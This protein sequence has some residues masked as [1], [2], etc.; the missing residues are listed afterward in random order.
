[1][2]CFLK[3]NNAT[4]RVNKGVAS[5][6]K[7]SFVLTLP[8]MKHPDWRGLSGMLGQWGTSRWRRRPSRCPSTSSWTWTSSCCPRYGLSSTSSGQGFLASRWKAQCR[9]KNKSYKS[10]QTNCEFSFYEWSTSIGIKIGQLCT[11]ISCKSD[12]DDIDCNKKRFKEKF[13]Q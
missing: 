1:M 9:S 3:L 6:M 5:R 7:R 10:L 8:E 2:L 11:L 13:R 4:W 12:F